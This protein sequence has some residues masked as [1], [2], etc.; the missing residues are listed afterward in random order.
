MSEYYLGADLGATK[1]HV[2]IATADGEAVGFGQSGPGNHEVGGVE[3]FAENL[4]KAT[5]QALASAHIQ[6]EQIA[7]AGLGV[8]GYDWPSQYEMI[9]AVIDTLSIQAPVELANDAVPGI[10]AAAQGGWGIAV[11]SGTGCNCWGWD[12]THTRIGHVTGCGLEFGEAGGASEM[13]LKSIMH[14]AHEYTRRGPATLL[15]RMY[16]ELTGTR[17]L[18]DLLACL[19]MRKVTIDA[20][21]APLIFK[22]AEQGDAVAQDIIAWAGTELGELVNAVV[23]QLDFQR[24]AFD[25]VMLGSAFNGGQRLIEPMRVKIHSLAPLANLVRFNKPPV[26]GGVLM[27]MQKSGLHVTQAMRDRLNLSINQFIQ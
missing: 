21:A 14:V 2:L 10:A 15:S 6:I 19:N 27:G 25:V 7:G 23:R 11:V 24:L 13:V 20:S 16:M 8:A 9:S 4:Q 5:R 17:D 18:E 1:T 22:A 3:V 12:S 26:V